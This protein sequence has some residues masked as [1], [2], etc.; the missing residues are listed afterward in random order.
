[1][2]RRDWLVGLTIGLLTMACVPAPRGLALAAGRDLDAKKTLLPI[3]VGT[4]MVPVSVAA[5]PFDPTPFPG[6]TPTPTAPARESPPLS[7]TLMLALTCCAVGSVVG[8][9]VVGAILAGRTGKA[10]EGREPQ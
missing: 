8:V 1:M 7:L 2:H 3:D 5:L 4:T 10:K 9:L 6:L